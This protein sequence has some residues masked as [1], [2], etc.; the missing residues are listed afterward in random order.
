MRPWIARQRCG[1]RQ[2]D[3]RRRRIEERRDV[4]RWPCIRRRSSLGRQ[5]Q[6][7]RSDVA[8]PAAIGRRAH[9]RRGR[10]E[11]VGWRA[12]IRRRGDLDKRRGPAGRP[13]IGRGPEAGRRRRIDRGVDHGSGG[14]GPV[15]LARAEHDHA[16]VEMRLI[17]GRDRPARHQQ[18]LG[19]SGRERRRGLR[20]QGRGIPRR[21]GLLGRR[22]DGHF[23]W[24]RG[25]RWIGRHRRGFDLDVECAPVDEGGWARR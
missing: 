4:G 1:R 19:L 15:G 25:R 8:R 10:R 14:R 16:I 22:I 3:I 20:G 5:R 11:A 2:L 13:D 7:R 17:G 12:G 6:I 23:G 21:R 24:R 9:I 18:L